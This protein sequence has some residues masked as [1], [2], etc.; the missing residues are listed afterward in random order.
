[1]CFVETVRKI[2]HFVSAMILS[3]SADILTKS[4]VVEYMEPSD[5]QISWIFPVGLRAIRNKDSSNILIWQEGGLVGIGYALVLLI[6]CVWIT[7]HLRAPSMLIFKGLFIGGA[8]GNLSCR[9]FRY[10][11]SGNGHVVDCIRLEFPDFIRGEDFYI[12]LADIFII[13]GIVAMMVKWFISN[14]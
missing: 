3:A 12:N 11:Y 2:N 9:L 14:K 7:R 5:V 10:P 6:L 4:V 1:M 8:I 13:V